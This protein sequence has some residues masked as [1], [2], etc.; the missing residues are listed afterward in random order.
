[1]RK[2][3]TKS[4]TETKSSSSSTS[5]NNKRS[6]S[7]SASAVVNTKNNNQIM[8]NTT[9]RI[10]EIIQKTTWLPKITENDVS[11]ILNSFKRMRPLSSSS[12]LACPLTLGRST[13]SLEWMLGNGGTTEI[14]PL[15]LMQETLN[16]VLI[17]W[18]SIKKMGN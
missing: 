4:K 13:S 3:T 6:R 18:S 12:G 15:I 14:S 7:K 1:M 17:T 5:T 10:S 2:K 8:P 16:L 9:M 11:R